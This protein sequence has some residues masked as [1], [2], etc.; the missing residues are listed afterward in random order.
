[1]PLPIAAQT[2]KRSEWSPMELM[3][4]KRIG[5]VDVSPDGTRVVYAVREAILDD[6][7][8]EYLTRIY[9][10]NE[11]GSG[12]KRLTDTDKSCD[13]PQGAPN[14]EW[15]AFLSAKSGK[16]T[17][18]M[19]APKG[20]EAVQVTSVNTAVTSFKWSPDSA[21]IAYTATDAPTPEQDKAKK[22]KNDA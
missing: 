10:V 2:E 8:S 20:G 15:I 19:I 7:K 22:E 13:T 9:L 21:W 12:T 6:G 16:R 14:G 17:V 3:K 18:W 5:R 4:V 1:W 11:G